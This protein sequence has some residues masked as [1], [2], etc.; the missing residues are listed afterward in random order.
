MTDENKIS[1]D[2]YSVTQA[3]WKRLKLFKRAN[4]EIGTNFNEE[5]INVL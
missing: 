1:R 3:N 5:S 4:Y 2:A